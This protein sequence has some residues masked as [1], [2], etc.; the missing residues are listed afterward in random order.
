MESYLNS[1]KIQILQGDI[2]D[3]GTGSWITRN[4]SFTKSFKTVP[5]IILIPTKGFSNENIMLDNVTTL[6][7]TSSVFADTLGFPYYYRWYA[8][9]FV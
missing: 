3:N 9:G 2:T 6:G 7:F 4:T 1:N 8:I 5:A